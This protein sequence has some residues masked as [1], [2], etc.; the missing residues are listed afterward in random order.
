[1]A[2]TIKEA[3]NGTD[4][5]QDGLT[6][7]YYSKTAGLYL[8]TVEHN[9]ENVTNKNEYFAVFSVSGQVTI[10]YHYTSYT[11]IDG[12]LQSYTPTTV[13]QLKSYAS[14]IAG[15]TAEVGSVSISGGA[16]ESK[17][18]AIITELQNLTIT[19]AAGGSTEAK[20]DAIIT[21]LQNIQ[22]SSFV[23]TYNPPSLPIA[24]NINT[25][26]TVTGALLGFY[27]AF[28]VD[29]LSAYSGVV[30]I[31]SVIA[32][33]TVNIDITNNTGATLDLPLLTIKAIER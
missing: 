27:D 23:G 33:N 1:M 29:N 32:D 17:Q 21:E 9:I 14:L 8:R 18:D 11:F 2:I 10:P 15:F 7:M 30:I 26:V 5:I 24:G 6:S 28:V 13:D 25:N 22:K 4:V 19:P 12:D 3:T 16:T 31:C 20:Q